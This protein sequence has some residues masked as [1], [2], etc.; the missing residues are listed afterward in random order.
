MPINIVNV[1]PRSN[2][3]DIS[4][5]KEIHYISFIREEF[6]DNQTVKQ[7]YNNANNTHL[8]SVKSRINT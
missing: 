5:I 6:K 3:D 8:K 2:F 7:C 4:K 1:L